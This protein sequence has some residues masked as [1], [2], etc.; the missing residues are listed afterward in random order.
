M[1]LDKARKGVKNAKLGPGARWVKADFHIH[2][3]TSS[4]Y[5]YRDADAY[6]KLG[7]ELRNYGYAVILKHEE[8]P[9]RDELT[10]LKAH[11][12]NTTLIPGAEINVIVDALSKKI[13]KDYFFHC[14]VA[15]DP[16][17]EGDYGYLLRRAKDELTY[18]PGDYPAGFRSSI[19]DVA[20]FF[21]DNG[22]IFIPAH[23]HQAKAPENSRSID[24]VYDDDAFLDFVK[25]RNFTALEV[26]LKST[27]G[28]FSGNE[29]T[30]EGR[31]IPQAICV[32]SSDAH[33]HEHI[34]KRQKA[35]WLRVEKTNFA[36]LTAALTFSHRV[37]LE[38][39]A[40]K[41]ARIVGL[42]VVGSFLP[43]TWISLNSDM[44]A[45]IGSKGSGKTALLECIRFVLN[46]P[47]PAERVDSV[48]RHIDHVLGSAGY[49][50]CLI[51]Q[52]DGSE[53]LV[54][55]RADSPDRI[56]TFNEKDETTTIPVSDGP[57]LPISILGW[58][59]IE[60]VADKANARIALLDRA[61]DLTDVR[62]LYE[63]I[64]INIDSLRDELPVLQR[65]VK[66][67]D[68][69]LREYW[70]IKSKRETL[71]R[72]EKSELM[73]LQQEYE[74]HLDAEQK[75][76][77]IQKAL[78]GRANDLPKAISSAVVLDVSPPPASEREAI[79]ARIVSKIG[80]TIELNKAS[81]DTALKDLEASL[82]HTQGIVA[83]ALTTLGSQFQRFRDDEYTPRVNAL[84]EEDREILTRQIQ[85]LEETKK[86]PSIEKE[87]DDLLQ[88]V[89]KSASDMQRN[90][91]GIVDL[92]NE[93]ATKRKTLVQTLNDD[94]Q[95]VRLKFLRSANKEASTLFRDRYGQDGA[96]LLG[97]VSRF[98]KQESFENL[99]EVFG[100]LSNLSLE[101]DRWTVDKLLYDVKLIDF[102]EVLDDDDVELSLN[103][104]KAG[105]VPIQNLSAGQRSVA[106]FPLLLRNSKGPLIV[107]QPE[108]N[109]DNRY[110][111]DTISPD[112]LKRKISQQY[113]MTSHNASLVVL[114]DADLIIHVDSDGAQAS[115]PASGFL[116]CAGSAVKDSVLAVLDGGK[117][118]L[119]ARQHKYGVS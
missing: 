55:R 118:A 25:E 62:A 110:I 42:H 34:T 81:E 7:S 94:L 3:P 35:T 45:L 9:T 115:F 1:S 31:P 86:L 13:G 90:C 19:V 112:L 72:L 40:T 74:W 70:L 80:E 30:K 49:V 106:V 78:N 92:R 21:R 59:E 98:G 61:G 46:T 79:L 24:D 50:E 65:D 83:D 77:G 6:E 85:V 5:E 17:S 47:V 87:C 88:E 20:R 37:R 28:F 68:V 39:P 23:L 60:A 54:M 114:T 82:A 11:C 73:L 71:R 18:R 93:V 22:A 101:E 116:S 67:L 29:K 104:G 113:L 38:Q 4:D 52:A 107:D 14:I 27:A 91:R 33:H 41:H 12:P 2:L 15:V 44:N 57:P 99:I 89:R 32:A 76:L 53:L 10:K 111:A 108:D 56:T 64:R 36:E 109:L 26:R 100:E 69:K 95:N 119:E 43:E 51:T 58:H 96:N 103:V 97:Y 16:D 84:P 63:K 102:L 8:F 117:A 105:F 66:R 48:K 75:L